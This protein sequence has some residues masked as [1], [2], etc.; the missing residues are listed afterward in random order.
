MRLSMLRDTIRAFGYSCTAVSSTPGSPT[1]T[2]SEASPRF[3]AP[4]SI[5]RSDALDTFSSSS[6]LSW[7]TAFLP[8]TP[9]TGPLRPSRSTR[10]PTSTCESHPPMPLKYRKPSSSMCVTW[11]PISSMWPASMRRGL[12]LGF[13]AAI[14]LPCTSAWTSSAKPCTSS[15]HTR[16]G[17]CSNPEGP[18]VSRSFFRKVKVAAVI[19]PLL[20]Q[21]GPVEQRAQREEQ[22]ERYDARGREPAQRVVQPH[23]LGQP[24]RRLA[25][26]A[27]PAGDRAAREQDARSGF[28]FG[29]R[30]VVRLDAALNQPPHDP[31]GEHPRGRREREIDAH[32]HGEGR[33]T[34]QLDGDGEKHADQH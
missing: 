12:P 31:T 16:A 19:A 1:R 22:H 11:R 25:A 17:A 5:H 20:P 4:M 3:A 18:A 10:C 2:R 27:P 13:T 24:V 28:D 29:H 9:R 23:R 33:H 7:C 30:A 8:I 32:G 21:A 34:H 26:R 15:R 14:E 6:F